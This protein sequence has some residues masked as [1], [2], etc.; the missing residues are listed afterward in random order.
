MDFVL[1]EYVDKDK[2][3]KGVRYFIKDYYCKTDCIKM[4]VEL[5]DYRYEPI[6]ILK[7]HEY[8]SFNQNMKQTTVYRCVTRKE[9]YEKVKEKYDAKCLNIVLKRLIDDMFEW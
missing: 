2:L 3:V 8:Y 6:A 1:F 4:Y 9:Y 5:V 7:A